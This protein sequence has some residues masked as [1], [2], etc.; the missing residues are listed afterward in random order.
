MLV[1]GE[2]VVAALLVEAD[3]RRELGQELDED[4]GVA[5]QPQGSDG[6]GPEQE[7]RELAHPVGGQTAADALA[8]D[9][10]HR[11]RFLAHLGEQL[12]V[13]LEAEL[14]D[15]TERTDESQRILA[16]AL[17]RDGA[18]PARLEIGAAAE[19]V[20]EVARLEPPEPSR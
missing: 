15:E 19:R 17:S 3:R 9:E 20:D 4:T 6:L 13:G 1:D 7:L 2:V 5:R 10:L 12:L 16:E 8:R 14:R 18:E 11:R